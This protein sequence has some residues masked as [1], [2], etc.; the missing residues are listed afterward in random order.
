MEQMEKPLLIKEQPT[1]RICRFRKT[2]I[3]NAEQRRR[4]VDIF[5]NSVYIF[6]NHA[7]VAFNYRD[8]SKTISL[9]DVAQT[10]V[11][12]DLSFLGLRSKINRA[13]DYFGGRSHGFLFH[14]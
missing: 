9:S 11:G 12:S 1:Y 10:S 13:A 2:E 5:V 8:G 3:T 14:T 7:V 6:D 4:L